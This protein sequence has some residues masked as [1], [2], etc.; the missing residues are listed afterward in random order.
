LV[1]AW[2]VGCGGASPG[3]A[4]SITA[5]RTPSAFQLVAA[6]DA[7]A[8]GHPDARIFEVEIDDEHDT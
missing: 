5:V 7:A 4:G 1:L 3:S 2:L 8:E 6:V